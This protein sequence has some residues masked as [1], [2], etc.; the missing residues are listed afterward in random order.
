[1]PKTHGTT[2]ERGLG[3]DH[4]K[5]R[6][7]LLPFAYHTACPM[8]GA[9]MWP[10]QQLDLDHRLPRV[11]GGSTAEGGGQIVHASCNR[12]EGARIRAALRHRWAAERTSEV[13]S[14]NW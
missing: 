12:A 14:R 2:T 11:F 13:R 10:D 6:A 1:M 8:C 7:R 9:T 3:W 4:Q 5:E